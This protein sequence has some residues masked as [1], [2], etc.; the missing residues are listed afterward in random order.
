LGF[1]ISA[2]A[3]EFWKT[4]E[5]CGFQ[6]KTVFPRVINWMLNRQPGE[7]LILMV[8]HEDKHATCFCR[9]EFTAE[10]VLKMIVLVELT[11]KY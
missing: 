7:L 5:C 8:L 9:S 6:K 11:A 10:F 3:G 1:G 4:A 2:T